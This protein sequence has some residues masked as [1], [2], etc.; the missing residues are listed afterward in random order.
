MKTKHLL[1]TLLLAVMVPWAAMG[2]TQTL[3]VC[4]GI[5]ANNFIPIAGTYVDTQGTISEFI[6][7]STTE[8]MANMVGA[9]ISKLTFYLDDVPSYSWD[10]PT[11]QWYMGEVECTTLSSAYGPSGFSTVAT[12]VLSNQSSTLEVEF[13]TPEK[14]HRVLSVFTT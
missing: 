1:L 8:G 5:V 10:S 14:T 12:C 2:Q 13:D 3:T 7:P 9:A 6:I 11:F 4:D